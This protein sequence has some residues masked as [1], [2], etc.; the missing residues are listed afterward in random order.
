[1]LLDNFTQIFRHFKQS[2]TYVS[3]ITKY[4]DTLK[5]FYNHT[6]YCLILL[7]MLGTEHNLTKDHTLKFLNLDFTSKFRLDYISHNYPPFT[8]EISNRLTSIDILT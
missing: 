5:T 4:V 3:L 6:S 8:K 1:M 2:G 7:E